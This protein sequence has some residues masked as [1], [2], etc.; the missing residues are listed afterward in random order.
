MRIL[1]DWGLGF[2]ALVTVIGL[3][4]QS[5]APERRAWTLSI[6]AFGLLLF[7]AGVA[8][9]AKAIGAALRGRRARAASASVGYTLTVLAVVVL[10]NF[11]AARHT[12]FR[13]DLTE[14]RDFSLSEQTEKILE[15]LPREVTLTSFSREG[16][17]GRQKVQDLLEEYTHRTRKLTVRYVDPDKNPA[18][19]RRYNV[20]ELG[21]LVI[22]SGKQEQRVTAGDEESITNAI[23][24][25]TSDRERV[26]YGTTGHGE[27]DLNDTDRGGL[28][29]L[30][31]ALE[32]QNYVVKP[33][34]LNAGVPADASV[35]IVDGPQKPFL[36][37]EAKMLSD[38][39]DKGGRLLLMQDPGVDPGFDALLASFGA[40]VRKDVVIDKVSQLFG[41][42][43]RIPMV[44]A[45]GYD[46]SH[47]ITKTFDYQT[48]YPLASS[49]DIKEPSP[50]GVTAV[51]LAR[52]SEMSWGEASEEEF[53][54]GHIQLDDKDTRGPIT[55]AAAF[56][57]KGSGAPDP[58]P[59]ATGGE[60]PKPAG[61]EARLVLF[62]DGDF[63][64]N[65]YFNAG[66]NGDLALSAVAWLAEQG[67]LM[68]IR[69]K[70]GT[71][72]IAILSPAH[73]FYYFWTIVA[74]A[75]ILI[76]TV[77]VGIWWR[78]KRL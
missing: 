11:L 58:A 6:T 44:P 55:L 25:V 72:R 64:S 24:K 14:N 38:W 5:V 53:K 33:L 74:I 19:V 28:S 13:K 78:R 22:E 32:K 1:R 10:I 48:I 41:G 26:V 21:T 56:E 71:P 20:T 43:A 59:A 68:S 76:A 69:P 54:S 2:G 15:G 70:T 52:T 42:D 60:A 49:I 8:L 51:K 27:H 57:K 75:P 4:L 62:G 9:N 18:E 61:A 35:V 66:G 50:A 45:D 36:E 31:S 65:N 47:P 29:A 17:P 37:A 46:R 63:A 39:V 23:I 34:Q 7:A 3:V 16:D 67:E 12:F 30:K 73:V 77:G 40:A